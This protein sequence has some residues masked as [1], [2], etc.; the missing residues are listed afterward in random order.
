MVRGTFLIE[1]VDAR[2]GG[3]FVV[4]PQDEHPRGILDLQGEE[5]ADG[6][7]AL[8]A[9]VDVVAQEEVA[10]LGGHASVF[11]ESQHVVVLSVDIAANL[12]RC[13]HFDQHGLFEEDGLGGADES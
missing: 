13:G 8:P 10:G 2:D 12:D 9:A 6:L 7:D 11:E 1:A 4:A 5:E 3:G